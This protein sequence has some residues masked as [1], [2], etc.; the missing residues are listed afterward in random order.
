MLSIAS[1]K[2][3]IETRLKEK[4]G[5]TPIAEQYLSDFAEAMATA[6]YDEITLNAE[7]NPM[8]NSGNQM[9]DSLAGNVTGLGR[10]Q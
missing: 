6:I 8:G 3:K 5:A 1:L 10:V 4:F 2:T 7:V 9:K